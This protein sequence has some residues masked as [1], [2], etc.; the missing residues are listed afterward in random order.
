MYWLHKVSLPSIIFPIR[1]QFCF[2][3][4]STFRRLLRM[5]TGAP[6]TNRENPVITARIA[7]ACRIHHIFTV[8]DHIATGT[9]AESSAKYN[10]CAPG[11]RERGGGRL[12]E[13]IVS[14]MK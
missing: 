12:T 6:G 8:C 7:N 5:L 13:G 2:Y 10:M 1:N 11:M 9:M 3:I 14:G 4:R